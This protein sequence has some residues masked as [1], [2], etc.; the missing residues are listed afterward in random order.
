MKLKKTL[1]LI[2]SAVMLSTCAATGA[3][4][5]TVK[6]EPTGYYNQGFLENEAGT[7]A[8]VND[9]GATY[10]PSST[11]WKTWS[12]Q[13]SSVKLRLYR[14]GSDNEAGAG[15]INEYDM[16]MGSGGVWSKTLSGDY[17]NVYYT[18]VVSVNGSTNETQ[19]V[20]SKATGVNGNRSMVVDLDSTD[21][22]GWS[23][24]KHVLRN[25]ATESVVWEVH[26]RDFS[27]ADNSGVSEENKGRYLA[28]TEGGTTLN[29]TPGEMSTCID[30]LVERGVNT[31]QLMPVYDYGSVNEEIPSS[32]SNRNWGYDPVNY[33]VPEG[34]YSTNP[35]DGNTRITEFKKMVQ[36]LHD[37]NITVV[38][39]VVY[40]HMYSAEDSSFHKTVPG[41]YFRKSA[42]STY[43]NG[44][45]CGNETASDKT[46]YRKFMIDSI[47]YW[48]KEYHIDGFRFDLMA[49]HD[50][51]TLNNIRSALDGLYSDGSGQK[52]LMYGEPW[53][54]GDHCCPTPATKENAGIL[55]SRVGM[56]ND[57][58]RD[59]LKGN[60]DGA[61]GNFIQGSEE[62]TYKVVTGIK[63]QNFGAQLPSQTI[64]YADAHDNLIL[65]DKLA[66]SNNSTNPNYTGTQQNVQ[67]QLIGT[68][69]L[70][71]TSKGIPFMTAGSEMGRT[72]KG[73]HNSYKSSDDINE[74]DWSRAKSMPLLPQWYKTMMAVRENMSVINNNSFA[75][76]STLYFPS[77]M[78]HV[79]A[80]TYSNSTSG[81]WS[82]VCVL[83]NNGTEAY[84]ISNL[85]ASSWTV[86]AN[87]I[88][89]SS[90]N[91]TGANIQ[92]I[93]TLNSSSVTVP[94]KGTIVLINNIAANNVTDSFGTLIV[95]HKT[96]SGQIL[97]TQSMR[98][99]AGSTYRAYP[100]SDISFGRTLVSSQGTVTGT[101][102]ANATYN[103]TFIY[104]DNEIQNGFLTVKYLD[105][106]GKAVREEMKSHLREG[107]SY[108]LSVYSVSGYE[109]DTD[110]FPA[111]TIG[112]FDGNDK[113][114]T[115]R[116]KKLT[117]SSIK[118]HYYNSN[119][120]PTVRMYSYTDD[121]L[122][123]NGT[124]DTATIMTADSSM[125]G[126]WLTATVPAACAYILFHYGTSQ[127]PPSVGYLGVGEIWVQNGVSTFNTTLKTSHIDIETGEKL[128]ADEVSSVTN[129]TSNT[130]Y[131]T[132]A[133]DG[134]TDAVAP[135]NASGV[136]AP[137]VVNVVY[138]YEGEEED[139]N[140]LIIGDADLNK[141]VEVNDATQIQKHLCEMLTLTGDAAFVSD[142][143]NDNRISIRDVTLIQKYLAEYAA[144]ETGRVGRRVS[145]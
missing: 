113:V 138:R 77:G 142:C 97:K 101:V 79:V 110:Q 76:D 46:M 83:Y 61:I 71:M 126:N 87:S 44:S 81:Q 69:T 33:N 108:S 72:K 28:F 120:W 123:P 3:G 112:T 58:Y 86:V 119:S 68:M 29:G 40:N 145:R 111:G 38:M 106:S 127:D 122:N 32:S 22:D 56:F 115:F 5:A 78:G 30:Y 144:S 52:I 114:V 24:D 91:Q 90:I 54:G 27:I 55:N 135:P 9:F 47:T 63:G 94:P 128:A 141:A 93:A 98:Y 96:Q 104:S 125:G 36:A 74:M 14:T 124:W 48:A 31:V 41:Y 37:R 15:L 80:Y 60:T 10:S 64:A 109:L 136:Y 45:G 84:P 88:S 50:T 20:Y 105:Q 42:A 73:D 34:S 39:D 6:S 2:L 4:A 57:I 121:G 26:V 19:D 140:A 75:N 62:D 51:T 17:K 23:T 85:G 129:V 67:N 137:G 130:T 1:S 65:W 13:A 134:R 92:G 43:S 21:P 131:N 95:N 133:L 7:A 49:L 103:V 59:A 12:P 117:G 99:R 82:K 132:S 16:T 143:N 25:N 70:L 118:V 35:Y 18:Y 8:S 116:Y 53:T 139:P 66:L 11:T 89:G 107:D 100:D 102:A